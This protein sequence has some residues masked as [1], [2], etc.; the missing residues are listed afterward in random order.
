MSRV[1]PAVWRIPPTAHRTARLPAFCKTLAVS[2]LRT[3]RPT[4]HPVRFERMKGRRFERLHAALRIEG[5]REIDTAAVAPQRLVEDDRAVS[6]RAARPLPVDKTAFERRVTPVHVEIAV[7]L[8]AQMRLV[9]RDL[10]PRAG[11]DR[12]PAM[13]AALVQRECLLRDGGGND[14]YRAAE[15]PGNRDRDLVDAD[16]QR[17]AVPERWLGPTVNR[18]AVRLTAPRGRSVIAQ[19]LLPLP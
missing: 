9:E 3:S 2:S 10:H 14:A 6:G 18:F 5:H 7:A 13:I 16:R 19:R 15:A 12:P 4:R 11:R 8:P 17:F 1:H